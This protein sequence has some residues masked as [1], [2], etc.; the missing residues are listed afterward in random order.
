ML[1]SRLASER[2]A[3]CW[4]RGWNQEYSC[5]PRP[6]GHPVRRR[7]DARHSSAALAPRN[8]N[9]EGQSTASVRLRCSKCGSLPEERHPAVRP[10]PFG[11]GH[12][13][14]HC[15]HSAAA[16]ARF[17]AP[18]FFRMSSTTSLT[19]LSTGSA[20]PGGQLTGIVRRLARRGL[21]RGQSLEKGRSTPST[22]RPWVE[23][24]RAIFSGS[25]SWTVV[26]L[27]PRTIAT[28]P[29]RLSSRMP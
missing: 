4:Q 21:A 18:S 3:A 22:R 28:R 6:F 13:E 24:M 26:V 12:F 20:V 14:D 1:A 11:R 8:L 19:R 27:G 25:G 23:C 10:P 5:M 16:A 2:R 15:A 7:L 9:P 17:G 29:V